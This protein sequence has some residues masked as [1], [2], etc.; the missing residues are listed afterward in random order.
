[1][2]GMARA[3]R[4]DVRV[5]VL[6]AEDADAAWD[7]PFLRARFPNAQVVVATE[8]DDPDRAFDMVRWGAFNV[9]VG[10][11]DLWENIVKA[12]GEEE[13]PYPVLLKVSRPQ[14]KWGFMSMSFDS[15]RPDNDD[16]GLGVKPTM[17]RLQLELNRIDEIV[18]EPGAPVL[19]AMIRKTITECPALVANI[20][21]YNFN[22]GY[23]IGLARGLGKTIILLRRRGSSEPVPAMIR[24]LVYIEY[25]SMVELSL[26]LFFG[27]GGTRADLHKRPKSWMADW[28]NGEVKE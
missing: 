28:G 22:T 7:I 19:E 25:A 9:V 13:R 23:E 17:R 5:V 8:V 11:A 15:A 26:R 21:S 4:E 20:S 3:Q 6:I 24:D 18:R 27:L 1:M 12:V 2:R 16:Y 14:R 10:A